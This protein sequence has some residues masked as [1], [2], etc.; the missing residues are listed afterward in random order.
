M[1]K[2]DAEF[3]VS[4]AVDGEDWGVAGRKVVQNHSKPLHLAVMFG[5]NP[6]NR[7]VLCEGQVELLA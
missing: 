6:A 7:T 3:N 5:Y 2:L 4:F 1:T